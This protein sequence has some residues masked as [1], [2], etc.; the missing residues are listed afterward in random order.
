MRH[1][2]PEDIATHKEMR[3]NKVGNKQMEMFRGEVLT[4]K[5][6]NCKGTQVHKKEDKTTNLKAG[7]LKHFWK[8]SFS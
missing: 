8:I 4:T 6:K 5:L 7:V 2:S 3:A 1:A